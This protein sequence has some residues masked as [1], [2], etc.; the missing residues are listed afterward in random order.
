MTIRRGESWGEAVTDPGDLVDVDDDAALAALVVAGD[1]RSLRL[2]GGDVLQ[3]LGGPAPGPERQRFSLDVLRI[4]ADGRALVAAAHVV[5]RDAA[6]RGWRGPIV[7]IMNVDRIGRWDVAPPAHPNDGRA[8][9][10][11]VDEAMALRARWQARRRLPSGT[12]VPHPAIRTARVTA[13]TWRFETPL[14]LWVDGVRHGGVR[15]LDLHVEPD[16][17]FVHT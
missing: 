11:E 6:S 1:R 14:G 10:V 17:V 9:V 2:R 4:T 8:D 3:T 7:A 13:R 16:A 12:H 5:A 15:S